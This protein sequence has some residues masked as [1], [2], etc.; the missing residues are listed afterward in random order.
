MKRIKRNFKSVLMVYDK[1]R[2]PV[3]LT[4]DIEN[5]QDHSFS[6]SIP[7]LFSNKAWTRGLFITLMICVPLFAL[8]YGFLSMVMDI[9]LWAPES[10]FIRTVFIAALSGMLIFLWIGISVPSAIK[11]LKWQTVIDARGK[12][13]WKIVDEAK[14]ERFFT[15]VKL[16]Q[17]E[18]GEENLEGED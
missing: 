15:L 1:T 7:E 17:E 12:G 13:N 2:R 10:F 18:D 5:A 14:W 6:I 3:L 11:D 8:V 4:F 16:A 9:A